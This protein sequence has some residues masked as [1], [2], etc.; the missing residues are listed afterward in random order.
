MGYSVF[1][2]SVVIMPL[3]LQTQLGY[4]ATWSG[5]VVAPYGVLALALHRRSAK[6]RPR[7]SAP[8]ATAAFLVFAAANFLRAGFTLARTMR[9]WRYLSSSRVRASRCSSRP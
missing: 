5:L 1:F 6:V 9:R 7:G 4:T 8:Y 3:W 2:G